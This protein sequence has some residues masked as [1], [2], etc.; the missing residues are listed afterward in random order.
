MPPIDTG[1]R[2]IGGMAP[3]YLR[4]GGRLNRDRDRISSQAVLPPVDRR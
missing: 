2:R 1:Q 3:S 4:S